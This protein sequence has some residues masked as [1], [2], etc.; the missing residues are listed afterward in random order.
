MHT[1]DK[2]KYNDVRDEVHKCRKLMAQVKYRVN[3]KG[4]LSCFYF[5]SRF[6]NL[7]NRRGKQINVSKN[8][9]VW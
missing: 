8:T 1:S 7:M 5:S 3:G 6:H 4:A 2:S 9:F